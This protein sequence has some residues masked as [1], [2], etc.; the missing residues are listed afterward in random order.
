MKRILH[1]IPSLD[2]GGAERLI[3]DI[4]NNTNKDEV[5]HFVCTL[6]NSEFFAPAIRAAGYEVRDFGITGKHPWFSATSK[7][8]GIIRDYQPDIVKTWL[9]DANIIG[10]LAHL[11]NPKI[12]LITTL[13]FPD[14]EPDIIRA[15]K[16]SPIKVEG[17]RQIDRATARLTK[18]YFTACSH[19]VKKSFQKRLN[20]ADSQIKVIYNGTDPEPL[21]CA[22]GD[23][24]RI[25]RDLGIPADG[26]VYTMVSR[27]V[28]IKNQALLLRV[29]P[30]VLARVPQA[31]LVIVGGG[32]LE[33]EL[34]DLANSLGVS[35]RVH[36]LGRRKDIGA[37]LEMAD[38]FVF[39]TLAEGFGLALVEAMF[40]ELPCIVSNI[41]VLRELV[42][43]N[44]TGLMFNPNEPDELAAAMCRLF[45]EPEL[46]RR[47]GRQA[48]EDAERR[49]HIR[50]IASQWED[51]YH[52]V[53]SQTK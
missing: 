30:Q 17:L 29:F 21:K 26:F 14:Y 27:L 31:Y 8:L 12:P 42:T 53:I 34:K 47:L 13:H 32:H 1:I 25:R 38:V 48:L 9:Y 28:E 36:F 39:T 5:S 19:Y 46:R 40:K 22:E 41:E 3:T 43:D 6:R 33:Q 51:F 35:H 23:A 15:Y 16:W 49:F 24:A 50:V 18:P 4:V 37:C 20:L 45:D 2:S 52:Q 44:E 7:L 10:R 11:R